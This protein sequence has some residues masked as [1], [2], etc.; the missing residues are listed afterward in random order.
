[1]WLARTHV[2]EPCPLLPWVGFSRKLELQAER[3]GLEPGADIPIPS[4][5]L[6]LCAKRHPRW[7]DFAATAV[8]PGIT[9]YM[10]V[11]FRITGGRTQPLNGTLPHVVFLKSDLFRI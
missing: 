9:N 4:A 2:L 10:H 1:M 7:W 11:P 3:L 5:A 6:N 8:L